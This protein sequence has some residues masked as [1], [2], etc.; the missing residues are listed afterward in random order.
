MEVILI[1]AVA[2][3]RVIGDRLTNSIPWHVQGE[4]RRFK[5]TTMGCSLLMGRKTYESIGRPL[6]GRQMVIITRN[7]K[8]TA[9]DCLIFHTIEE[10]LHY[11]E[12]EEKIFIIGG[13]EIYRQTM[14]RAD[15]IILTTLERRVDG[16][17]LFPDF[18]HEHFQLDQEEAIFEP[19]PYKVTIYRRT[20]LVD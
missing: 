17:I 12:Q 18:S 5:E 1:A 19:E 11:C 14:N 9:R 8:Y 2:A 4:Q 3:N 7:R 15:Q 20:R 6:P 10:A 13:E 16:D